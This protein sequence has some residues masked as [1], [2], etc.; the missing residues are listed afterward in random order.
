MTNKF[1]VVTLFAQ[2]E[3]STATKKNYIDKLWGVDYNSPDKKLGFIEKFSNALGFKNVDIEDSP[4]QLLFKG[5]YA[6]PKGQIVAE[7][8]IPIKY[9]ETGVKWESFL[10]KI[11]PDLKTK[12][13]VVYGKPNRITWLKSFVFS[14]MDNFPVTVEC[15]LDKP[16]AE[17]EIAE[18][19]EIVEM[20]KVD[21]MYYLGLMFKCKTCASYNPDTPWHFEIDYHYTIDETNKSRKEM[22][23]QPL[24]PRCLSC[25]DDT[26]GEDVEF[27]EKCEDGLKDKIL[28][29][30]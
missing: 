2:N 7:F 22:D 15:S 14:A 4:A 10:N 18:I 16:L 9:A 29:K 8:F 11:F 25:L 24:L 26:I 1:Y 13:Q 21:T 19:L 23:L 12:N 27:C 20:L 6:I 5:I 28:F 30:L 17:E 3:V